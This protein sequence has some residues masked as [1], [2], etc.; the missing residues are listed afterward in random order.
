M[1]TYEIVIARVRELAGGLLRRDVARPTA[2]PSQR[3]EHAVRSGAVVGVLSIIVAAGLS[4]GV[5][6]ALTPEASSRIIGGPVVENQST[7]PWS[8]LITHDGLA[9]SGSIIDSEHVIT[10]AHCTQIAGASAPAEHYL[11]RAG[12]ASYAG[13]VDTTAQQSRG[14]VA[15]RVHPGYVPTGFSDDVAVLTLDGPLV[16]TPTV[17]PIAVADIAPVVG[18]AVRIVGFGESG[19]DTFDFHERALDTVLLPDIGCYLGVP[20]VLCT[21][22]TNG[23]TC[24]GDSG[25]G[26]VTGSSPPTLIA[27]ID[28]TVEPGC[29][30]GNRGGSTNLTSPEIAVWLAGSD[31]PP[32]GP[33]GVSGPEI[34]G[35]PYVGGMLTCSS[36][37]WS[38]DP[39]VAT[40]FIDVDSFATLQSG[41]VPTY[42]ITPSDVGRDV[43]C[44]S[45][46]TNAGGTTQWATGAYSIMPALDPMLVF[47]IDRLG[48]M[49]IS[50][51]ASVDARLRLTF[52]QPNGRV[53]RDRSFADTA[54]PSVVPDLRPGRYRACLT[55]P[56]TG[57]YQAV[58]KCVTWTQDGNAAE[59]VRVSAKQRARG[60]RVRVTLRAPAGFGLRNRRVHATWIV[61]R[62][63][64]CAGHRYRRFVQ[65]RASSTLTSPTVPKGRRVSLEIPIPALTRDGVHY[66][67]DDLIVSFSSRLLRPT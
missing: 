6:L 44:V 15:A 54:P 45:A 3:C 17:S 46:A 53:V 13:D 58:T 30:V 57:I 49:T 31:S 14:V 29:A 19:P 25:S 8:V 61:S 35:F 10:A 18:S 65:L 26:I 39:V 33:R 21:K 50:D 42:T 52:T 7:A 43:A 4:P 24:P 40:N 59:L 20:A 5:A 63:A 37:Q 51:K 55:F 34:S 48:N 2:S 12:L 11:V 27:V 64:G 41:A 67:H 60:R 1:Q 28:I 56:Q 66:A 22:T 9:C 38:G 62:C 23:A 47:A 36:A 32:L 16:V